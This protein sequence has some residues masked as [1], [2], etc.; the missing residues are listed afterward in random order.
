M[1]LNGADTSIG[2]TVVVAGQEVLVLGAEARVVGHTARV[3]LALDGG[4]AGIQDAVYLLSIE[5]FGWETEWV[6]LLSSAAGAGAGGTGG[7]SGCL[8]SGKGGQ[9]CQ[10][11]SSQL[12]FGKKKWYRCTPRRYSGEP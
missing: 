2:R 3:D 4:K 11:N 10:D 7:R 6:S 12:H 1:L 9:R 5:Q 8:S